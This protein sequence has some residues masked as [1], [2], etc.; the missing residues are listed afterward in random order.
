MSARN[1]PPSYKILVENEDQ[2][3]GILN[4]LIANVSEVKSSSDEATLRNYM[5]SLKEAHNKFR[6]VNL[7]LSNWYDKNAS[8]TRSEEVDDERHQIHGEYKLCYRKLNNRLEELGFDCGSTVTD[9]ATQK[10]LTQ[11]RVSDWVQHQAGRID[12]NDFELQNIYGGH[13]RVGENSLQLQTLSNQL[14]DLNT[15]ENAISNQLQVNVTIPQSTPL[16]SN[17]LGGGVLHSPTSNNLIPNSNIVPR[18]S[19]YQD[20]YTLVNLT[21]TESTPVLQGAVVHASSSGGAAPVLQDL[22]T[23]AG[24]SPLEV[25]FTAPPPAGSVSFF[26][27]SRYNAQPIYSIS[28]INNQARLSQINAS[29][30][31]PVHTHSPPIVN[32]G[33]TLH[34]FGA[35]PDIYRQPQNPPQFLSSQGASYQSGN[36][37]VINSSCLNPNM[38][39]VND[40]RGASQSYRAPISNESVREILRVELMK[41]DPH[42]KFD[43]SNP[44]DFWGW[45]DQLSLKLTAAGFNHFPRDTIHAL[46]VHLDKRPREFVSAYINAG[47]DNPESVLKEIWDGLM[48]RYGANDIVAASVLKKVEKFK[49]IVGEDD[50]RSIEAMEDLHALCLRIRRLSTRCESLRHYSSPEG[51]RVLWSKMPESFRRKWKVFYSAQLERGLGVT[52][53][54]LLEHINRFIRINS[55]PMFRKD[56]NRGGGARALLTQADN[57]HKP[58]ERKPE[59]KPAGTCSLHPRSNTHTLPE[60]STFRNF[61]Y[62]DRRKHAIENKLCFNCL[63][64]HQSRACKTSEKCSKCPG[65]HLTLMHNDNF[66]GIKNAEKDNRAED[67]K[68]EPPHKSLC[69][70]SNEGSSAVRVCSKTLPIEIQSSSGRT[71]KCLAILDEQSTRTFVDERVIELLGVPS[72][73]CVSNTYTLSTMEQLST[74]IEGYLVSNL[75]V[76]SAKGGKWIQLPPSLTHPSIPN[77]AAEA[78]GPEIVRQHPHIRKFASSFLTIDP[79][80]DVMVLIGADCGAAMLT[81]C[82]GSQHPYVHKTALGYALVGPTCVPISQK[83]NTKVAVLRTN[84][85]VCEHFKAESKFHDKIPRAQGPPD[86]FIEHPDDELPGLSKNHQEFM[87][88]VS[89]GVCVNEENKIQVPLPFKEG[90]TP[91]RNKL[92]VY[93]RT[94]NTLARLDRDSLKADECVSIIDKYLKRGHVRQLSPVEIDCAETFIPIFPVFNERKGKGRIVFDSSAKFQ[95]VS[96]NDCLLQGPDETNRLIGVLIRFRHHEVAF[97]ADVEAM[98]H[99]FAVPPCQQKYLCFFWWK[100]NIRSNPV[101]PFA[102]TVHVF[103]NTSSPSIA[104]FGLR[105]ATLNEESSESQASHF[106]KRQFYVDDGLRSERTIKDAIATLKESTEML[107]RFNIRLHKFAST[108]AEVL[109]AFPSTEIAKDVD[110]VDLKKS[111]TQSALGI[112]WSIT[113]DEFH[114]DCQVKRSDFTKRGVLSTNGSL[115]DPLGMAAPVGLLGKLLQRKFL[116]ATTVEE[117]DWDAP[118]PSNFKEEWDQWVSQL[119]EVSILKLRRCFHPDGFGEAIRRELHVFADA[120]KDSIG[121]VI[122]LRQFNESREVAVAFVLGSSRVAPKGAVSIPRLELC[123]AVCAVDSS[124]YLLS[125]IDLD[126]DDVYYYSDSQIVLGYI[127]N[128]DKRFSRYVTSRIDRILS[129]SQASQWQYIQTDMNPADI[130]TRCHTPEQLSK[131]V[132]LTGPPFL[133]SSDSSDTIDNIP[134]VELPETIQNPNVLSSKL[135]IPNELLDKFSSISDWTK[136]VRGISLI[137]RAVYKF[138]KETITCSQAK[139]IGMAFIIREVQK[140]SFPQVYASLAAKKTISGDERLASLAPWLDEDGVMRVGG[141]LQRSDFNVE[142]KHPILLPSKHPLTVSLLAHCHEISAHQGRLITTAAVRRAGYHI[143]NPRSVIG[144]FLKSCVVCKRFRGQP[145]TQQMAQLPVDRLEQCPPFEHSGMD[146]F[147]PYYISEGKNTRRNKSQKKIWVL[148]ITCLYSRAVHLEILTS[149]DTSTFIL[150]FRRF[151]ALRGHCNLLRSDRGS[152]FIGARNQSDDTIDEDALR[153]SLQSRGC[154]WELTPPRASHMAGVWERKVGS[155]KKVLRSTMYLLKIRMLDRDEFE[156]LLREAAAIVNSTPLSEIS[157]DPSE[158]FPVCPTMLLTLREKPSPS[159]E[160][161]IDRDLCAYGSKR[162]RRSQYL[163]DQF[164]IRWKRDYILDQQARS[165]WQ[166][167]SRN[168]SVGDVV[169]VKDPSPRSSWPL[170][171]V[172]KVFESADGLVRKV[173][174]RLQRD[175][176]GKPQYRERAVH[177]LILLVPNVTAFPGECHGNRVP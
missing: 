85:S 40:P 46:R 134:E 120:S 81:R 36:L 96:L 119:P 11:N 84:A 22:M 148:I 123:A 112:R 76:R 13:E 3:K 155:V 66:K 97:S 93:H 168:L 71:L 73:N 87:R 173:I 94:C 106:I 102:A 103:G 74:D 53:E 147:G 9:T 26:Q 5:R 37:G 169:L 61:S 86:V 19:D 137:I 153:S 116:Q 50:D 7:E 113:K 65:R 25:S 44:E 131:S 54:N 156:T 77:T 20:E 136:I 126:I 16:R 125:E 139:R 141:R 138:R 56:T 10:D 159:S 174:L 162:W 92:S 145:L 79:N 63:A 172:S 31:A 152:N 108:H 177:D 98:F 115:F 23:P 149:M 70:N 29:S 6:A 12:Q 78:A 27:N 135:S 124:S 176:F 110:F 59:K 140:R 154:E 99:C 58:V 122:Y 167:P 8:H 30:N 43:G 67:T 114:L 166:Y 121:H 17:V 32:Q 163:A 88:I 18:H 34:N 45:Y 60:C 38:H 143:L 64:S 89:S 142:E 41:G 28:A 1:R 15:A 4:Q 62:E 39:C 128:R 146:V 164:W 170:A 48:S 157:C 55:N 51:M 42:L 158:P 95:G 144:S 117:V 104:T 109:E 150:A 107:Q 129:G 33:V 35:N 105:Y 24:S 111:S 49:P 82:Y 165:K 171:I 130:A 80:L 132:W 100:D 118:L 52:F 127:R 68:S 75:Q 47:I 72:E 14:A 83:G 2:T 161:F 91:P 175:S 21:S 160:E 69:T 57:P 90:S 101:V 133:F 151:T